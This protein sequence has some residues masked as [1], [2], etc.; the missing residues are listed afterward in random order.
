MKCKDD[1]EYVDTNLCSDKVCTTKDCCVKESEVTAGIE[2]L[3]T[4]MSEDA[5]KMSEKVEADRALGKTKD[6]DEVDDD[7]TVDS[8][9]PLVTN[10]EDEDADN[11]KTFFGA[12]KEATSSLADDLLD[13]APGDGMSAFRFCVDVTILFPGPATPVPTV[14]SVRAWCSSAKRENYSHIPH[15]ISLSHSPRSLKVYT[16]IDHKRTTLSN[17]NARTQVRFV[18]GYNMKMSAKIIPALTSVMAKMVSHTAS[19]ELEK[20]DRQDRRTGGDRQDRRT[21][22]AWPV[23][24]ILYV[25]CSSVEF[26]RRVREYQ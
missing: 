25:W 11:A 4:K 8:I 23:G 2:Y 5:T 17:T 26:E 15:Q 9:T 21:G 22:E 13:Y 10:D 24:S 20:Y 12:L 16:R 18:G 19:R 1:E 7:E 14:R 6:Y 3:K